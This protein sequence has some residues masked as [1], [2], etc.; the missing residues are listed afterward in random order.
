MPAQGTRLKDVA[1]I[2]AFA[3]CIRAISYLGK[4]EMNQIGTQF[5][6]A[7]YYGQRV[8]VRPNDCSQSD[9]KTLSRISS[10][11]S[12]CSHSSFSSIIPRN[13]CVF[14]TPPPSS[15]TSSTARSSQN[16]PYYHILGERGK[17]PF[18]SCR[19]RS[20]TNRAC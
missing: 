13:K 5:F 19:K 7:V 15:S 10:S 12:A 2:S 11:H 9:S 14:F 17:C 4:I 18:K 20:R 16:M 1:T 6:G 8:D 3:D